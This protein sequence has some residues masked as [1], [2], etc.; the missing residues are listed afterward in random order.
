MLVS[1]RARASLIEGGCERFLHLSCWHR[2]PPAGSAKPTTHGVH[3]ESGP[4]L[5]RLT[6]TQD[7]TAR[8]RLGAPTRSTDPHPVSGD[9]VAWSLAS[10][11]ASLRAFQE[12]SRFFQGPSMQTHF[13]VRLL[14]P[15]ALAISFAAC[16]SPRLHVIPRISRLEFDGLVAA[17]GFV[18][19]IGEGEGRD[20][21]QRRIGF[22][23]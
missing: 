2:N 22:D 11:C 20:R 8:S 3:V 7:G 5:D 23:W 19:V 15:L 21:A 12:P 17:D 4:D 9:A 6:I 18:V 1:L 14:M 10:P 13:A 16:S